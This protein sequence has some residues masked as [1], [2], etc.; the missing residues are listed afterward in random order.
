MLER[1]KDPTCTIEML[2]PPPSRGDGSLRPTV[3]MSAVS[4]RGLPSFSIEEM[5]RHIVKF[6]IADNQVSTVYHL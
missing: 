2:G 5:H 4:E 1:L 3:G 6:I